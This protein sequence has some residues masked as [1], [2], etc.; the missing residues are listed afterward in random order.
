MMSFLKYTANYLIN[1]HKSDFQNVVVLMPNRRSCL[2]LERELALLLSETSWLPQIISL[3]D[4]LNSKA[5]LNKIDELL[6]I[7]KLYN[8]FKQVYSEKN[9][10]FDEFYYTGQILLNDFNDIDSEL[11]DAEKL[12]VNLHD[13]K[14]ISEKFDIDKEFFNILSSYIRLFEKDL[15]NDKTND[16]EAIQSYIKIW[17]GLFKLYTAFRDDL[18]KNKHA[19]DGLLIRY[20][21][22]NDFEK[23]TEINQ[24]MYYIVGFNALSRAEE[25]L[26]EMLQKK[27]E[28]S[29]LWEY[30]DE[31]IQ[32]KQYSAGLY[33]RELIKKF[34]LPNDFNIS[35]ANL[36]NNSINILA[37]PNE[38]SM[39][40]YAVSMLVDNDEK[41]ALVLTD[42]SLLP[43]VLSSLPDKVCKVNVTMGFP[44][45]QTSTYSLI[46]QLFKLRQQI[47]N[48]NDKTW[49]P[50]NVWIEL[51]YHPFIFDDAFV[52]NQIHFLIKE[53]NDSSAFIDI[54]SYKF[55][56][57]IND[58]ILLKLYDFCTE[59]SNFSFL[60]LLLQLFQYLEIK[61]LNKN[62]DIAD[63]QI[64]IQALRKIYNAFSVFNDVLHNNKIE[65]TDKRLFY[66]LLHQILESLKIDLF[67][68]PLDGLQV[69]G[70]MESR[71]LDFEK[72]FV[73]SLNDKII[74]GDKFTP[75]FILYSLRK[76]FGLSTPEKREAIDAFH[77]YRLIQRSGQSYLFYSQ[78]IG[79]DEVDKSPYLRQLLFNSKW[80][81][82]EKI[83]NDKIGQSLQINAIEIDKKSLGEKWDSFLQN[84][85]KKGL[86]QNAIS[87][88]INCPLKFYFERI[89][90]LREEDLFPDDNIDK[91]FGLLFH[92][93]INRLFNNKK[94]IN[95]NDLKDIQS[96]IHTIVKQ[97]FEEKYQ[98]QWASIL[99]LKE[100]LISLL[101]KFIETEE[102]EKSH[103]PCEIISIETDYNTC[104]NNIKLFGRIDM[105]IK[106]NDEV[107]IIDFKTGS[108]KDVSLENLDELFTANSKLAY[109]FQLAFYCFLFAKKTLQ[110]KNIFAENIYV[111]KYS[112]A[113]KNVLS[114]K[115]YEDGKKSVSK[116][117]DFGKF[118]SDFE[119][120][121]ADK[122]EELM[123]INRPFKQTTDV[124][125]CEYC[126]FNLICRKK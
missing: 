50:R 123:D 80:N 41:T 25:T 122:L 114:L 33:L 116:K 120:L 89:E 106:T 2:F 124:K 12:F 37:L 59:I 56:K 58:S 84:I 94:I 92:E 87:T 103:F 78:F 91:D 6:A 36:G 115:T 90:N 52:Q 4:W 53:N 125:N 26:F 63:I 45:K 14:E 47:R 95:K 28:V 3:N 22:E 16:N 86:S 30:D 71:L 38:I 24:E 18:I 107:Y 74:P 23:R 69:M 72:V 13:L 76:Y 117:V 101:K 104:I 46:K 112:G 10:S 51:L 118:L 65:I 119:K 77:F 108:E 54:K 35:T 5:S 48:T 31:Y 27:T 79:N 81:I 111:K 70:L 68:E 57:I 49:I 29:F 44:V 113:Y 55:T 109:A 64:E 11:V 98:Y 42:E 21:I 66:R 126:N 99:L 100:Q 17:Q 67:G 39:T 96:N 88:F 110:N 20:F 60:S 32:N 62:V 85:T 93:A 1:K 75:T 61:L 105:I 97:I 82:T 102:Q 19:Y 121:L 8:A 43:I 15:I 40:K 7:L 9:I 83:Y 34:P 73:L